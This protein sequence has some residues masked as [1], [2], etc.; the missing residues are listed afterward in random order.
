[1]KKKSRYSRLIKLLKSNYA[2]LF[3]L[4]IISATFYWYKYDNGGTESI[5][6]GITGLATLIGSLFSKYSTEDSAET[7][8]NSIMNEAD[9]NTNKGDSKMVV[10]NNGKIDT[11]VNI[12]QNHGNI[13]V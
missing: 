4:I 2:I 3:E 9:S 7:S 6:L 12:D 5:I 10:V 1:M 13:T 8:A 11:Q